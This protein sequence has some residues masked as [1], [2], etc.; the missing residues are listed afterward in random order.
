MVFGVRRYFFEISIYLFN[1]K[2][3]LL[4][5][6]VFISKSCLRWMRFPLAIYRSTLTIIRWTFIINMKSTLQDKGGLKILLIFHNSG[7]FWKVELRIFIDLLYL[8]SL[9]SESSWANRVGMSK[10]E[11]VM[12]SCQVKSA[13]TRSKSSS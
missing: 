11:I 6:E 2:S 7:R 5:N 9:Y 1:I 8:F 13:C 4:N 12:L 10:V 3:L